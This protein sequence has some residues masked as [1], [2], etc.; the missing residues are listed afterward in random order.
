MK[1]ILITIIITLCFGSLFAQNDGAGNT[2]LSFLKLGI[3]AN[4]I[5]MGEAFSSVTTD[6]T[7][8][9]YNPAR[10]N[11]GEMNNVTAMYYSGMKDLTTNFI[12]AKIKLGKLGIG[13][14]ALKTS[15]E[16]I[17]VRTIPGNPIDIFD[18]QDFSFSIGM[19]YEIYKDLSIGITS[20]LLY[21]KIF[22][23]EA[24]GY[25]FDIGTSYYS[26]N[27]SAS[28]VLA[29]LG[30]MNELRNE[31]TKLPTSFR[32]GSSYSFSKN[33]F[34][35]IFALESFK[36]LDGGLLHINSGLD[37]GFKKMFFLRVGYQTNYENRSFTSGI[38][39]KYKNFSLDYAFI[40]QTLGFGVTNAFSLGFN[41]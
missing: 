13:V 3:G 6:A 19:G 25:S 15:V 36:I 41:F 14:G 39:I 11:L 4:A 1:R 38:G 26:N 34:S 24:S 40:P 10:L 5:A 33:D 27:F 12:A 20:K 35:F 17:E 21:E 8:I 28:F 9:F 30:S 7:A 32:L 18:A 16:G 2:G 23:D 37:I 31:S 22:V 29:N